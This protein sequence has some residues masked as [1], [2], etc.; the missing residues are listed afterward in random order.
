MTLH[1]GRER[2]HLN[3][4]RLKK[5]GEVFEVDIDPD[6]A[7]RFRRGE[8]VDI[9]QVLK[10]ATVFK[11]TQK[12]LAASETLMTELFGTAD[13][14]EVAARIIKE[15]DIQLTAEYRERLREAKKRRIIE[16]IHRNGI[17]P[18]SK[19]PHPVVRIE[20]ALE[21]AKVRIDEHR[22]AE[23]Q[24]KEIVAALQL[25]LPI[26]FAKKEIWVHLPAQFAAKAYSIVRSISTILQESWRDDGSWEATVEIPGGLEEEF[27]DK[28]NKATKGE[29]QT[30]VI[31]EK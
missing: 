15:G 18:R 30:K 29:V 27:H 21:E 22:R 5:S 23:E 2:V 24:V 26:T 9:H 12:G 20:A 1:V 16:I 7:L 14:F 11:N 10:A 13:A 25:V 8:D 3:L 4:A 19:L 6:L 17:D 28:L 31:R